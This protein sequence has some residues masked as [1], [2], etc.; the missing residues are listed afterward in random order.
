MDNAALYQYNT[1]QGKPSANAS[2][3]NSYI[4]ITF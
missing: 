1:G 2:V 4:N 3:N